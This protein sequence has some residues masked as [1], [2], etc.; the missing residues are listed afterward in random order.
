M[1]KFIA[2]FGVLC[3]CHSP[4]TPP[5][6]PLVPTA[7]EETFFPML[8][9][10]PIPSPLP[11]PSA[12]PIPSPL[13]AP[14]GSFNIYGEASPSFPST[15]YTTMTDCGEV[16][17]RTYFSNANWAWTTRICGVD[18]LK[19]E[20]ITDTTPGTGEPGMPFWFEIGYDAATKTA[21]QRVAINGSIHS[22]WAQADFFVTGIASTPRKAPSKILLLGDSQEDITSSTTET[23]VRPTNYV[24]T[25]LEVSQGA[26]IENLAMHGNTFEKQRLKLDRFLQAFP[27][28]RDSTELVIVDM[29][30][31][32]F[33][34]QLTQ[35]I[36]DEANTL[37][38]YIRASFT[39][40]ELDLFITSPAKNGSSLYGNWQWTLFR[41]HA[42]SG[43]FPQVT[44]VVDVLSRLSAPSMNAGAHG[45]EP[46]ALHEP[47]SSDGLH[48]SIE[49]KRAKGALLREQLVVEGRF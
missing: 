44:R 39:N 42:S 48:Y 30:W 35:E 38:D 47:Y 32:N 2:L 23:Q 34:P 17:L 10:R 36:S 12:S 18:V 29:G 45:G 13:P 31:N 25:A 7:G 14:D 41:D 20:Y 6:E 28:A 21:Y 16:S 22:T 3:A 33:A 8:S 49:G 40:A 4:L 11:V 43:G 1:K 5:G 24:F 26:S 19:A 9:P 37:F 15:V 27:D 46:G